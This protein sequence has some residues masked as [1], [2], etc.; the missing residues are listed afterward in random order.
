[1]DETPKK[2]DFSKKEKQINILMSHFRMWDE[3]NEIR[4]TRKGGWDDITRAYWGQLPTQWPYISR[5]T[6]P[7][8]R[9]SVLEKD[10]RLLNKKPKGK[11]LPRSG[12]ANVIKS[13]VQNAVLSLQWDNATYGGTMQEKLIISSQDTRLYSSK[14]AFVY[15]REAINEKGEKT[16]SGNE[17]KPLDIRDCGMDPKAT[18]IRDAKWFQHRDWMFV[19]DMEEENKIAGKTVWKNLRKIKTSMN[20][21]AAKTS[22]RRDN[23]RDSQVKSIQGLT[24]RVGEDKAYQVV[25]VITEYTNGK[26]ESFS[27]KYKEMLRDDKNPFK[28]GMIP[29]SQLRYYPIQDDPL[30]ESEVEPLL[31]LWRAIQATICGYLDEMILKMRP[32]LKIVENSVRIETIE[33]GPDAQWL[34]DD[35]D[36][37]TEMRGNGEAQRWFETTYA[38]LVSAFNTAMGDLSQNVSNVA[39]FSSEKT[40]TEIKATTKQQNARDQRNQNELNDFIRDIV[41]MWIANNRQFYFSDKKKKH[42]IIKLVGVDQ[43]EEFM[44]MGLADEELPE[45]SMQMIKGIL[46]NSDNEIGESELANMT[47]AAMIPTHPF[48]EN[49]NETDV[50]K[51]KVHSKLDVNDKTGEADL[52]VEPMDFD[53][54]Y[55]FIVDVKSMEMG[56]E[57]EFIESRQQALA[58]IK[59]P[60]ILQ[61]LQMEGYKP[62]VRDLLVSVLNE[63]GLNDSQKYFERAEVNPVEGQAGQAGGV[64]P[65]QQVGGLPGTPPAGPQG[66]GQQ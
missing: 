34:M 52:Y 17:M 59:D 14:F 61:L 33:R 1:M 48:V 24:D 50:S 27:P 65:P 32:P 45:E 19:E 55:D 3:D 63:G 42:D 46:D 66:G 11:V 18:H 38:A 44:K 49:P 51:L 54:D 40:A 47:Q 4:R 58:M 35:P 21:D 10:S 22:D 41:L 53:G 56:A 6:D 23:T 12:G 7:R 8:I 2:T 28:H 13:A 31:P 26:W 16:F 5:I 39:Q 20:A 30:G 64:Q 9:T 37:V 29:I 57:Q 25:E 62:K 15:W 43:Y 60:A 36:A